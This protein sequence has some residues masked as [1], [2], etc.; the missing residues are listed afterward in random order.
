MKKV[1]EAEQAQL[2]KAIGEH[3]KSAE[4]FLKLGEIDKAMQQVEQAMALD[5]KNAYAHAYKERILELQREKPKKETRPVEPSEQL[6]Q[7]QR[8]LAEEAERK[9]QE[10]EGKKLR[11]EEEARRRAEEE[12]QKHQAEEE[13]KRKEKQQRLEKHL[14]QARKHLEEGKFD[15][16]LDEAEKALQ[17]D[18]N[19]PDAIQLDTRIHQE[20]LEKQKRAEE[21]ARRKHEEE[22]R[23]R[24]EEEDR[25]HR[26]VEEAERRAAMREIEQHLATAKE[27]LD[28]ED[29][30]KALDEVEKALQLNP[31]HELSIQ[32]EQEIRKEKMERELRKAEEKIKRKEAEEKRR[33]LLREIQQY[34]E[35]A[36]VFYTKG[37]FEKAL[38]EIIHAFALDATHP[39]AKELAEKVQRAIEEKTLAEEEARRREEEERRRREEEERRQ[40]Q[41]KKIQGHL[42]SAEEYLEKQKFDKAIDELKRVYELDPQHAESK[43]LEGRVKQAEE[44][45]RRAQ[46]EARRKAEIQSHLQAAEEYLQKQK[47]EKARDELS[48]VYTLEK[49]NAAAKELDRRIVQAEEEA[50]RRAEEEERRRREE[51]ERRRLEEEARKEAE[52]KRKVEAILQRAEEYLQGS[53][54]QKALDELERLEEIESGNVQAATLVEKARKGLEEEEEARRKAE[55]E[56]AREV[57]KKKKVEGILQEAEAHFLNGEYDKALSGISTIFMIDPGNADA[58]ELMESVKKA[59]EEE[60]RAAAAGVKVEEAKK[61]KARKRMSPRRRARIRKYIMMG[62]AAA[63][64][65]VALVVYSL[66]ETFF[67]G[68]TSLVVV[69]LVNESGNAQ[70]DYIADGLSAAFVSDFGNLPDLRTLGVATS[71]AYRNRKANLAAVGRELRVAYVLSGSAR[72]AGERIE[73]VVEIRDTLRGEKLWS[74][75]Y[76]EPLANLQR[77]RED[78]F[79][80]VT[81]VLDVNLPQGARLLGELWSN[82]P[83][84]VD[85]YLQAI[86]LLRERTPQSLLSSTQLFDRALEKD[87]KFAAATARKA[88]ALALLYEREW[89]DSPRTLETASKLAKDAITA[90]SNLVLANRVLGSVY[91]QQRSY[92]AAIEQLQKGLTINPHDAGSH[93]ELGLVYGMQGNV[94][95]GLD[96]ATKAVKIDPKD[97]E[98]HLAAA[99]VH[100]LA[101]DY[102]SAATSYEQVASLRSDFL[103]ELLGLYDDALIDLLAHDRV[104]NLY[105]RYLESYPNDY[106]VIYR[107]ARSYQIAGQIDASF[108]H[109]NRVISLAQQELKRDSRSARAHM[110]IGLAQTRLGKFKEGIDA[111]TRAIGLAP[112]DYTILFKM[113]GLYSM[114]K[115]REEA[116]KWFRDAVKKRYSFK[117]ILDHDVYN[118]RN[119]AEFLQ[120]SQSP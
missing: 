55:E 82:D 58:T 57:E 75:Q 104:Q 44:E 52:R 8:E 33:A 3:L 10:A 111:A 60:E 42:Q 23:R 117:G 12:A 87:S 88:Y 53:K 100:H 77:I 105:S 49:E 70:E 99:L 34:L 68:P 5:P 110:Y 106:T 71:L 2:R 119:E 102:K 103:W 72:R 95:S 13:Q 29:F 22:E 27:L 120:I 94:K 39:Q 63:V 18:P 32:L 108:P 6:E 45:F 64:A 79:N 56:A 47:F 101:K 24:R 1:T 41:L 19:D 78:V 92:A 36:E 26:E 65:V 96:E 21:E 7:E 86:G 81:D 76:S 4:K 74:K 91:R 51:E 46:D 59:K 14:S 61:V 31:Q 118:I 98:A 48:R 85:L 89:E 107:L 109:L 73:I 28:R 25:R 115:K 37:K 15:K 50:R 30:E 20:K 9:R 113:A 62:S 116:L 17:L 35:R 97:F 54:Y 90:D 67:P 66:Q 84:A 11:E 114:Q 112:D 69:P 93:I 40:V 80:S 16:A 83:E 43:G 38:D